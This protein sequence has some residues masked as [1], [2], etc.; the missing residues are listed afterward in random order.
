MTGPPAEPRATSERAKGLSWRS[1]RNDWRVQ[2]EAK[3]T[4]SIAST[5][6]RSVSF[7]GSKSGS[8]RPALAVAISLPPEKNTTPGRRDSRL[9]ATAPPGLSS[10]LNETRSRSTLE[11]HGIGPPAEVARRGIHVASAASERD[12][13]PPHT[14][15]E[16]L[17]TGGR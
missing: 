9:R 13:D 1:K 10:L 15:R 17:G 14:D 2:G 12:R 11:S 3:E 5:S 6:A 8:S 4:R 7:M 16:E